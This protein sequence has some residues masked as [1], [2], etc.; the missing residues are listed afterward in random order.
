M[1]RAGWALAAIAV[2]WVAIALHLVG[3]HQDAVDAARG[4]VASL[5]GAYA[6]AAALGVR[7]IDQTLL[8]ARAL[9]AR[10]GGV[11]DL[12]PWVNSVEAASGVVLPIR[13]TDRDGRVTLSDLRRPA[14]P[15]DLSGRPSFRHFAAAAEAAGAGALDDGLF[16]GTPEGAPGHRSVSFA[17][18]LMTAKG[19]FDGV[20]SVTV[21]PETLVP[22]SPAPDVGPHG[23]VTLVGL[24]A[25]VLAQPGDAVAVGARGI[26]AFRSVAGYPL[27]LEVAL[28]GGDVL[29]G[30]R[31]S[32]IALLSGGLLLSVVAGAAGR[33]GGRRAVRVAESLRVVN[34][35]LE[36]IDQGLIMVDPDGRIAMLNRR[37]ADLL[38]LPARFVAGERFAAL[39]DWQRQQGEFRHGEP[40][41]VLPHKMAP[42]PPLAEPRCYRRTRP[43]GMELEVR[44]M[45]LAEDWTMCAYRDVTPAEP[46]QP[47]TV[48]ADVAPAAR[49]AVEPVET[50][51]ELADYLAVEHLSDTLGSD[52]VAGI[53]ATFLD[54]LPRQLGRMRGLAEVG[55]TDPLQREAHA[56]AGSAATIGL[57]ELGAAASELEQ[58]L[59][60]HRLGATAARLER[61]DRLAQSGLDRLAA[62]LHKRAA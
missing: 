16:I 49:I 41:V 23:V 6:A 62:Y 9:H 3:Q 21:D 42:R 2:I 27:L 38:E 18:A 12:A 52:A 15:M 10:D 51:S 11:P 28:D 14:A 32:A 45:S 56:L 29:P 61:I 24:D 13:M 60:W 47:V 53:V 48:P 1:L 35:M 55:D 54:V 31:G 5:A 46:E 43:N 39:V 26:A 44:I 34:A 19:E 17:R 50:E 36:H 37:A 58:D 40:P 33:L 59:K 7:N 8:Y 4:K 20:V 57:D 22:S 30:F 25:G